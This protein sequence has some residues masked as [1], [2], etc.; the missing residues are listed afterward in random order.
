ME[1]ITK[2]EFDPISKDKEYEILRSDT[3]TQNEKVNLLVKH[4]VRLVSKVARKYTHIAEYDD[5]MQEG[6]IGLTKAAENFDMSKDVKFCTYAYFYVFKA[7]QEYLKKENKDFSSIRNHSGLSFDK[8]VS[9]DEDNNNTNDSLETIVSE[10]SYTPPSGGYFEITRNETEELSGKID[11][12][13][14]KNEILD[15]REKH[16]ISNR[17]FSEKKRT[18]KDIGD[19]IGLS[20]SMVKLVQDKALQK[21]KEFINSQGISREDFEFSV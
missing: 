12:L 13:I 4:N 14:F 21:I 7:I 17:F 1:Q 16:I 10:S 6:V 9:S 20:H 8:P 5:M 15:E 11:E 19:E 3:L 2:D 18:L